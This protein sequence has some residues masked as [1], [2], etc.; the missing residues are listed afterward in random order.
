LGI[1]VDMGSF[2][3]DRFCIL[4]FSNN[5]GRGWLGLKNVLLGSKERGKGGTG[6]V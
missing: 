4:H 1:A 6:E 5:M 3:I 2:A